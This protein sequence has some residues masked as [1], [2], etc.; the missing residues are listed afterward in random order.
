MDS[1]DSRIHMY[2]AETYAKQQKLTLA[3]ETSLACLQLCS[4]DEDGTWI[5]LWENIRKRRFELG[6]EAGEIEAAKEASSEQNNPW[7][8]LINFSCLYKLRQYRLIMDLAKALDE[9]FV[10]P[11]ESRLDELLADCSFGAS[12]LLGY[13]ANAIGEIGYMEEVLQ[14]AVWRPHRND[15]IVQEREQRFNYAYFVYTIRQD[16][17]RALKIL[18][19][20]TFEY[21]TSP[22]ATGFLDLSDIESRKRSYALLIHLYLCKALRA[23]TSDSPAYITELQS[24]L[25]KLSVLHAQPA[26]KDIYEKHG[27]LAMGIWHRVQGQTEQAKTWLRKPVLEGIKKLS[28]NIRGY[29]ELAEAL[30]RFGDKQN[31]AIAFS[32]AG[33]TIDILRDVQQP[34]DQENASE[35]NPAK[36]HPHPGNPKRSRPYNLQYDCAGECG[37]RPRTW[38]AYFLCEC[39]YETGFCDQCVKLVRGSQLGF[40]I[41][42]SSHTMLQIYP[43]D[44]ELAQMGASVV[45]GERVRPREE[46][47][48]V[49]RQEWT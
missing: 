47:L 18:K 2:L 1:Q 24:L 46:W 49:L 45:D 37:R 42:Y 27:S 33:A 7:G 11:Y 22:P 9:S 38:T 10:P 3:I 36:S 15:N 48:E 34:L 43:V 39:C 25:G 29:F 14:R 40:L 30:L 35:P 31:A 20:L 16:E 44:M 19:D 28:G 32:A 21:I 26:E 6:D 17:S 4:G 12:R 8:T 41:C 13:V 23:T 5:S